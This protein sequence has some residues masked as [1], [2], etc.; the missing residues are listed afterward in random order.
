MGRVTEA[1]HA[2][3]SEENFQYDLDGSV[4]RAAN[5]D[6]TV[7]F[8][9]DTMGRIVREE[10]NEEWIE[11]EYDVLGHRTRMR[12][13]LGVDQVIDRNVMGDVLR[14]S[15]ASSGFEA[16]FKRNQLGL[17]IERALP[18]GVLSRWQRDNI[19]RPLQHEV[20]AGEQT[21]R[22]VGY[23]WEVND[24]L[25]RVVDAMKGATEYQHDALGNLAAARYSDGSTELRMPDAV[26][27]LFRTEQRDDREYGA[28][29]QLLVSYSPE[30]ETRYAYDVE[31]N[32][33][34]KTEPN[35]ACWRYAWNGAG[36]LAS[37]SRPDGSEVSFAYDPLGRRVKKTYRG[38]TTRWVW[39]GNVPLHEWVE[40]RLVSLAQ[41]GGV[42]WATADV[43][44]QQREA[45]LDAMLT[46]GPAE[47]A[48]KGE[49]LTWLF[50]PE[51]FALTTRVW[52]Q[53]AQFIVCDYL[54]IPALIVDYAGAPVWRVGLSVYGAVR[55]VESDRSACAFRWPG[56]YEDLETGLYYNRFRYYDAESGQYIRQDPVGL[57]GGF[58]V[59]AYA[60]DPLSW[61][62]PLGLSAC[63]GG[64]ADFIDPAR[65]RFSQD[66]VKRT[67]RNGTDVNDAIELL[68]S[69]GSSVA[70]KYPP[71]RLVERRGQLYTLDNR[72][73]LVFSQ[74]DQ[75]IPYRMATQDEASREFTRKFSTTSAQ[76]WGRYMSVRP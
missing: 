58:R 2:D 72:R 71:T 10:Q 65:V 29:G 51:S 12:S 44:V 41:A 18:G 40:G 50:E 45:E 56:Q 43:R 7:R 46:Q 52:A 34:S 66:S 24:R 31:G 14:V 68:A 20:T 22:A 37:V 25:R 16:R 64:R 1:R 60:A 67:F 73:L 5:Q 59:H 30:G 9:R 32:L 13:S 19:G 76:G 38:Q 63:P 17:E 6:M 61:A 15:E 70:A 42:P 3:G 69:G 23:T 4:R 35:G 62:D 39:N 27:N 53:E 21:L 47:Q 57:I 11:S 36:M 26:G 74:A 28:A 55:Q 75:A 49:P 48:S 8:Q 33:S 54:G